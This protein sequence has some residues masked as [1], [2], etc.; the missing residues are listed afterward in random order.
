MHRFLLGTRFQE[1]KNIFFEKKW[2]FLRKPFTLI[3]YYK[4]MITSKYSSTSPIYPAS[5][6]STVL[7]KNS[8]YTP[9]WNKRTHQSFTVFNQSSF[10]FFNR[11]IFEKTFGKPIFSNPWPTTHRT[12]IFH[13]GTS[14]RNHGLY[15]V[16]CSKKRFFVEVRTAYCHRPFVTN[17]IFYIFYFF[18]SSVCSSSGYFSLCLLEGRAGF[19]ASTWKVSRTYLMPNIKILWKKNPTLSTCTLGVKSLVWTKKNLLSFRSSIHC[20]PTMI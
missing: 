6:S 13:A 2:V 8:D 19:T 20:T 16:I 4:L 17:K 15:Q 7:F 10:A 12:R 5:S 14:W 3:I 18:Y 9:H 11:N 1:K